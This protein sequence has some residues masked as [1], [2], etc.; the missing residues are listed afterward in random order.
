MKPKMITLAKLMKDLYNQE[1]LEKQTEKIDL[2]EKM[3]K[4]RKN[5]CPIVE[6]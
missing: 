3:M 1:Q 6:K 5:D 2:Y 4:L